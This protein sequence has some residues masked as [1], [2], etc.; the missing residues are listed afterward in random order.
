MFGFWFRMYS[1]K[2]AF[3]VYLLHVDINTLFVYYRTA[4]VVRKSKFRNANRSV[5]ARVIDRFCCTHGFEVGVLL[6]LL[7]S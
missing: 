2:F 3:V 7:L 4:A 5:A 6:L 1:V